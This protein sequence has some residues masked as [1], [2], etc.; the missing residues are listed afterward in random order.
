MSWSF[1]SKRVAFFDANAL[2]SKVVSDKNQPCHTGPRRS[3]IQTMQ[4]AISADGTRI[5]CQALGTGPTVVIVGGAFSTAEAATPLAEALAAAGYRAVTFDRRARGNS[6][7]TAPY[8]PTREVEDLTAV[9]D[10]ENAGAAVLGHSSGAMLVLFAASM[11]LPVAHLFLS[12]PPFR[13]GIDEP[14]D[15]LPTRLQALVDHDQP[16]QAVTLFQREAVGLLEGMIE[17]IR[18]ITM[19]VTLLPLSQYTVY[20]ALLSQRVST[21]SQLMLDVE[22]PVTILRGEPTY[23]V[24]VCAAERLVELMP[25]A[26]LVIVPESRDH[27]LDPEGTVREVSK[28]FGSNA[29]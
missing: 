16:D 20:D 3:I 1:L 18:I 6:G 21:P 24:L 25:Q 28:R 15:N 26:E 22:V 7:D 5:A 23:P 4:H 29:R 2:T 8:A 10:V 13:F 19:F 9:L 14:A 17:Q 27:R 11:G 12:E